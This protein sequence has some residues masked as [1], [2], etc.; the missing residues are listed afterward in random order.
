LYF[1]SAKTVYEN[2]P[3]DI[4]YEFVKDGLSH[5]K[6]FMLTA[7]PDGKSFSFEAIVIRFPRVYLSNIEEK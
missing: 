1:K 2:M 6:K 3:V 7:A 5:D 4:G